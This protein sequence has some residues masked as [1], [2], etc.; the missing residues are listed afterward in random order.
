MTLSITGASPSPVSLSL[1][2]LA[3]AR[4]DSHSFLVIHIP[5]SGQ[6]G[7]VALA[8]VF[9]SLLG[10]AVIGPLDSITRHAAGAL[11]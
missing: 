2:Q 4:I 3:V 7:V 6:Q 5:V 11:F 8:V 10:F 9:V 1:V